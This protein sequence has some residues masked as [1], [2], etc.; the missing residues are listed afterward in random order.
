[1]TEPPLSLS[2]RLYAALLRWYPDDFR[3][4]FA[5]DMRDLFRKEIKPRLAAYPEIG[6][7]NQEI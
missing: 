6:A 2:E 4:D 3:R 7:F 1:M 5:P